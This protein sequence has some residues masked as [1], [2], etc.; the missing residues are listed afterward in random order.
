MGIPHAP[1]VAKE[2][3]SPGA[4]MKRREAE[5]FLLAEAGGGVSRHLIDLYFGLTERGW[6]VKLILSPL[7]LEHMHA[8]ELK[9]VPPRDVAYVPMRRSPH[10]ADFAT[11]AEVVRL[12]SQ[13]S[14]A[15]PR[16]KILH[17]HST[18]AAILGICLKPWVDFTVFT[19]HAFRS[20]D[21]ALSRTSATLI[22]GAEAVFTRPYDRV[23]T[24]APAEYNYAVQLIGDPERVRHIP[25]GIHTEEYRAAS[26]PMYRSLEAEDFTVGFIG[27]LV[28]QKNPELFLEI[29]RLLIDR[30]PHIR[31]VVVGDGYLAGSLRMK[32]E[33]LHIADRIEW[34][35]TVSAKTEF[36]R[37]HLLFHTSTYEGMPYTL[38]ESAAAQVPIV[39]TDNSG[40]NA[41]LHTHAPEALVSTFAAGAMVERASQLLATESTFRE[42]LAHLQSLS[43]A[44]STT[45]MVSAIE[46]EY[47][48]LLNR[49]DS[50]A[51][52]LVSTIAQGL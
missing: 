17:A 2:N 49:Q 11:L 27:R 40:S 47:F 26:A 46:A 50:G 25:N 34:L 35:G 8:L 20:V 28:R 6:T 1:R 3:M 36:P 31:A 33:A 10:A 16:K 51:L 9:D 44:F 23:I 12:V 52:H 32:A 5:I 7:R 43:E 41:V 38:I 45:A 13:D 18:K 15:R 39:S 21:P 30:Y 37:I 22:R 48:A 19:P 29:M 42:H 24:V 4:F 14:T